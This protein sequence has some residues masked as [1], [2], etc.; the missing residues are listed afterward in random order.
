WVDEVI[1]ANAKIVADIKGGKPSAVGSL[2]GQVMKKS[3]G[4]ANPQTVQRLLKEKL[5]VN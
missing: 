3:S 1:A 5:S 2:V 4:R